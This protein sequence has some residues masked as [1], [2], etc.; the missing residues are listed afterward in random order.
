[1]KYFMIEDLSNSFIRIS[2]SPDLFDNLIAQGLNLNALQDD[3][4]ALIEFRGD[5]FEVSYLEC[6]KSPL[7]GV[8]RPST[9]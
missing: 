6:P 7:S 4:S 8:S 9:C 1:M 3:N 5:L 2:N